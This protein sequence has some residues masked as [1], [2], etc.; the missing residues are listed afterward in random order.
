MDVTHQWIGGFSTWDSGIV[1]MKNDTIILVSDTN[2]STRSLIEMKIIKVYDKTEEFFF[3]FQY[4]EFYFETRNAYFKIIEISNPGYKEHVLVNR[5][6]RDDP[7][8]FKKYVDETL[9]G[10]LQKEINEDSSKFETTYLGILTVGNEKILV[11]SQ[12][13]NIQATVGSTNHFRLIFL[14]KSGKTKRVCNLSSRDE[15][16]TKI[17]NNRLK[18]GDMYFDDYTNYLPR[19]ICIPNHGRCYE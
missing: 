18:I 12:F 5:E 19:L 1:T 7:Y 16:P 2:N 15:F 9:L 14:D 4:E 13:S 8:K 11:L 3:E 6:P 10:V 17:E